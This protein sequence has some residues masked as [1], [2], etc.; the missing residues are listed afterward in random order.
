MFLDSGFAIK[1]IFA[2]IV[3]FI[4]LCMSGCSAQNKENQASKVSDNNEKSEASLIISDSSISSEEKTEKTADCSIFSRVCCIGDSYTAGYVPDKNG[5]GWAD[6]ENS[7]WPYHMSMLTGCQYINCGISG[8][9]A[10][11]WLNRSD[12]L[13]KAEKAGK[14]DAYII[15]LGINDSTE[16]PR[17]H[18]ELG[19]KSDIGTDRVSY[20]GCMA[21]IVRELHKISP[22]AHIF[23]QTCPDST[24]SSHYDADRYDKYNTAVREICSSCADECH[25][26]LLD[27]AAVKERYLYND[28]LNKSRIGGHFTSE[29]YKEFAKLLYEIW[30]EYLK[31]NAELFS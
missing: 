29:G 30:N 26:H 18:L 3:S 17:Y 7:A 5:Y 24:F 23:M 4:L 19:D 8:A 9:N 2:A 14:A 12:G 27:L 10:Y 15:G 13:K 6:D 16:D 22:D 11:D 21:K 28:V 1:F 31:D 25:T 20:Y